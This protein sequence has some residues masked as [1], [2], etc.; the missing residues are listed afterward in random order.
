MRFND[1]ESPLAR[2]AKRRD[3]GGAPFL[4]AEEVEAGERLRRDFTRGQMM[5]GI[6]QRWDAQPRA[7]GGRGAGDLSDSAIDARRRVDDAIGAVGPELSGVLLDFCCI[8][9]GM[10]TIERERQWP[11]RSAKILL[12]AGVG[13]LAR[14]YGLDRQASR[15]T[16]RI[17][18]WGTE[19]SRPTIGGLA[20]DSDRSAGEDRR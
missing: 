17:R 13:V 11:V 12:K 18:R 7:K 16:G 8:L 14:H 3:R 1:E 15:Q 20:P 10:E 19:D 9:K 6:S 5:P 4:T 2:L